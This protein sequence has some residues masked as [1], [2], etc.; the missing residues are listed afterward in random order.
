M[1]F[2]WVLTRVAPGGDFPTRSVADTERRLK[3]LLRVTFITTITMHAS[4]R[5]TGLQLPCRQKQDW[6][7]CGHPPSHASLNNNVSIEN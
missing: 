1:V 3:L 5:H 4:H 6:R 2:C 7:G